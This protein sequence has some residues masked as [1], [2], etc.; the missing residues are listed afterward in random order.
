MAYNPR[1]AYKPT[2]FSLLNII[3]KFVLNANGRINS[4]IDI[5]NISKA[6]ALM[7]AVSSL[8]MKDCNIGEKRLPHIASSFFNLQN[9]ARPSLACRV[10][11][12]SEKI[13][14]RQPALPSSQ[15]PW[16]IPRNWNPSP[17]TA[18]AWREGATALGQGTPMRFESHFKSSFGNCKRCKLN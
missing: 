7:P 3:I 8:V 4:D 11:T 16:L 18:T 15:T 10:L 13:R 17:W 9:H 2:E 5:E 6:Q 14:F 1:L 12:C